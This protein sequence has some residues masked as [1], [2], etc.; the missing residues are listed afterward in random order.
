MGDV[1][2][3]EL[4]RENPAASAKMQS[5]LEAEQQLDVYVVIAK[6]ERR[7]DALARIQAL[8]D[9]H[10]RV[11]YPLTATKVGKQFQNA[12]HLGAQVALLFGDEWP[13]VKV[14]NLTTREEEL[15]PNEELL[16]HL[17]RLPSLSSRSS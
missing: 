2:L 12:E 5:S 7:I 10:Y 13:Q 9:R 14:K 11:D 1:V 16:A 8:R 4:I 15:V 3:G 17:V 6:E